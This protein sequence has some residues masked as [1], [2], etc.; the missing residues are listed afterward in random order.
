MHVIGQRVLL[1]PECAAGRD[2]C[3]HYRGIQTARA[4]IPPRQTSGDQ[5]FAFVSNVWNELSARNP[6]NIGR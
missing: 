1:F 4:H 5:G 2:G 6:R 3:G